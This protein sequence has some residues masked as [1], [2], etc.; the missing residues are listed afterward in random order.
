M[1]KT[2]MATKFRIKPVKTKA[3]S[4]KPMAMAMATVVPGCFSRQRAK[5]LRQL[6]GRAT[7]G[8][9][10]KKRLRSSAKAAAEE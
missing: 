6:G 2:G 4:H 5:R 8:S 10:S 7:I 1:A 9:P 3:T